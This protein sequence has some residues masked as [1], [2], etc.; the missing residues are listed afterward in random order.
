M[1]MQ[2]P[3]S[4]GEKV[5]KAAIKHL[6]SDDRDEI[7]KMNADEL[8]SLVAGCEESVQTIESQ[9]EMYAELKKLEAKAKAIKSAFND[10]KNRQR[11][12]QRYAS[13]VMS[14]KGY[15]TASINDRLNATLA[16]LAH[17]DDEADDEMGHSVSVAT[18][19]RDMGDPIRPMTFPGGDDTNDDREGER[20]EPEVE[21]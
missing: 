13:I 10:A 4:V 19:F 6:S 7:E 21:S 9:Q 14:E 12:R 3:E 17:T 8:K 16:A 20:S 11:G 1:V 15:S 18:D 5:W 2:K